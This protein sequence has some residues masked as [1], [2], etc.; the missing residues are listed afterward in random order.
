MRSDNTSRAQFVLIFATCFVCLGTAQSL[1]GSHGRREVPQ[2]LVG[3]G[4]VADC[5]DLSGAKATAKLLASVPGTVFVTG[6]LAYGEGTS[7]ELMRCYA[8]TWGR[9]RQRTRPAL[10]NHEYETK[11]SGSAVGY[12]QYFGVLGG[13]A[14]EGYYSYNLG[15]W[16]I[17]VLN[18]NCSEVKGGCDVGSP[19]ETWLREDLATHSSLCQLAYFHHPLFSSSLP[20]PEV[21]PMWTDLYQAGVDLVVN[22]HAHN[23]ER[24]APQDPN[25]KID[26]TRGIREI[27]VGTGGK[28]HAKFL[29]VMPNSEVRN[30]DSFG[31]LKLTLY[32]Q[33][34]KWTFIPVP[35]FHFRDAGEGNCHATPGDKRDKS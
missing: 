9:Y 8:E 21:Q 15:A 11:D 2:V 18:S 7:A 32:P 30:N 12:F 22:G 1:A 17:I 4:D 13:P 19:Q 28:D 25:G 3:A 26:P 14:G 6:D 23:Y 31:V 16:H 27:I 5:S 34:Y 24:F 33:R 10:G 20:E 35:G 29:G